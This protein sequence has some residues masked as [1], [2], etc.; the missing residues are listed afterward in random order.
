MTIFL[1]RPVR[2]VWNRPRKL[3]PVQNHNLPGKK[4]YPSRPGIKDERGV[5]VI[6]TIHIPQQMDKEFAKVTCFENQLA[7]LQQRGFQRPLRK[8][9]VPIDVEERFAKVCREVLSLEATSHPTDL[10]K[11]RI[12]GASKVQLLACLAESFSGHRVPNSLLHTMTSL[13]KVLTFYSTRVD[14]LSPYD[15]LEQG[16]RSGDLPSN[17]TVQVDPLRF[18]P[19]SSAS[20][21][22][23]DRISAF[24]RSSTIL[25]TPEARKKWKSVTAKHSPWRN[26]ENDD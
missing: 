21:L 8:Y 2:S 24:P 16:V 26:S 25:S 7:S 15:R 12:E 17:L 4:I 6:E 22:D 9:S 14:M 1:I 20:K 19:D 13:D 11:I 3:K 10:T 5:D 23:V 18:D